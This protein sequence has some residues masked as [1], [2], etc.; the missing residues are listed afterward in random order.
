MIFEIGDIVN[1]K[2]NAIDSENKWRIIFIPFAS[3]QLIDK[4]PRVLIESLMIKNISGYVYD[5][6]W[7]LEHEL[8]LDISSIRERKLNDLG[9]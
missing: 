9:I 1:L 4:E 8:I 7:Y 5:Q 2:S 3:G 6:R